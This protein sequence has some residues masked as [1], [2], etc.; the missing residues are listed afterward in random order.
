MSHSHTIALLG[1]PVAH[2]VSP[3]LH[4]AAF[5]T[6]GLD[7]E[8]IAADVTPDALPSAVSRLRSGEWYGANVTIPH[9]QT[10]TPLLDGLTET[11]ATLDA[12]NTIFRD[13]DRL[14]GDNTDAEGFVRDLRAHDVDLGGKPALVL[15][16]GGAARA[17]V[18]ALAM[19]ATEVRILG[20]NVRAGA[21]LAGKLHRTTG[22]RILNF[23]RTP[24]DLAQ[25]SEGCALAVNCT[26]L[27]MTPDVH[28]TPWF[29]VVPFPP[30]LFVYDL[31]YNPPTTK[32]MQQA[33]SHK[34]R[35][36]GGLGMLVQQG[37]LAFERWTGRQAPVETMRAACEKALLAVTN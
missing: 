3:A 32:L 11:A 9:K 18:Y 22:A 16:T 1:H 6:L 5:A 31:V 7:Y 4:N 19:R 37:A 8:Y 20:R 12:V 28:S 35:G 15:G 27:G 21:D 26:P 30:G 34:L 24:T 29:P 2:S 36:A 17:V 23:A 33:R 13:G 25:A 10:I 14:I